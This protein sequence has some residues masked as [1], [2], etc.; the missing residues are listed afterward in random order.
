[1]T[2]LTGPGFWDVVLL[3]CG[4]LLILCI[5]A[6]FLRWFLRLDEIANTLRDIHDELTLLRSVREGRKTEEQIEEEEKYHL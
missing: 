2:I 4:S 6:L 1:M 3:A 5:L